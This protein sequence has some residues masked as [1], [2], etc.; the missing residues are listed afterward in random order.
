MQL[1]K[2]GD[3]TFSFKSERG[4]SVPVGRRAREVPGFQE[5]MHLLRGKRPCPGQGFGT[6]RALQSLPAQ[7]VLWHMEPSTI[8]AL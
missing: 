2:Q 4:L 1:L 5:E 6:R 8:K 7:T 3:G